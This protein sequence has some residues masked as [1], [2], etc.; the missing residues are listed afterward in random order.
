[1]IA[2]GEE[3][4]RLDEL[5]MRVAEHFDR[6]VRVSINQFTRLL[7]PVMIV[8]MGLAVGSVVV[9]MLTAIFSVND[10]PM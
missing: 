9:S 5:L 2:V 7:E 3:T 8:V 6:E 1:M 4:G 10:L